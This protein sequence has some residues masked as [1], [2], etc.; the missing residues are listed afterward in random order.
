MFAFFSTPERV[1]GVAN[2]PK[3]AAIHILDNSI[4]D[5]NMPIPLALEMMPTWMCISHAKHRRR[6]IFHLEGSDDTSRTSIARFNWWMTAW[7]T[8]KITWEIKPGEIIRWKFDIFVL[9]IGNTK[10]YT[11]KIKRTVGCHLFITVI[12]VWIRLNFN[13]ETSLW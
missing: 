9:I 8:S 1:L 3:T 7:I 4:L 11:D 6:F 13:V 12:T 5:T 2:Y 10:G